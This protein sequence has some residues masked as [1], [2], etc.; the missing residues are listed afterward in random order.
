MLD[1]AH[2][3]ES[4]ATIFVDVLRFLNKI[5]KPGDSLDEMNRLMARTICTS[6]DQ[7]D[8][9]FDPAP[10]IRYAIH[11]LLPAACSLCSILPFIVL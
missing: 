9:S 3:D 11:L 10:T 7:F 1:S 2:S 4:D 5:L 8:A 6:L